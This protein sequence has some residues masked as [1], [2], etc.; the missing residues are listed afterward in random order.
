MPVL[1][2]RLTEAL[3]SDLKE[4]GISARVLNEP[5]RRTRLYRFFVV[6]D[7][8]AEMRHSERQEVVWRIARDHLTPAMQARIS[9]ILTLTR[10]E[11]GEEEIRPPRRA[12]P[13]RKRRDDENKGRFGGSKTR[14]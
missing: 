10:E 1:V 5:V 6:S 12:P 14:E 11:M 8:F 2:D 3:K 4:A 7:A 13:R 9:M